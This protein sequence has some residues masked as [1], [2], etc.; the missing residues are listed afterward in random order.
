LT[1]YPE[2]LA[3]ALKKIA[4]DHEPLKKASNATA[5][6]FISNPFGS[7]KKMSAIFS[8]HPPIEDRIAKLRGMA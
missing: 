5:H 3:R 2:G 7:K 6:L 1:R 4:A 8:T